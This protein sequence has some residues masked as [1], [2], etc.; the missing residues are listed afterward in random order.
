MYGCIRSDQLAEQIWIHKWKQPALLLTGI[1]IS[2]LGDFI[3]LVAINLLVLK[4]TGS[5]TAVAGLWAISPL[6]VMFTQFWSGS[7]IDQSE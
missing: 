2:R 5:A 3:Y 6:A 7:I 4:M 1:G